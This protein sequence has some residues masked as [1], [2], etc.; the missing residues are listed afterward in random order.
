[1]VTS[2]RL[3]AAA[4]LAL[5]GAWPS[6][7]LAVACGVMQ[8]APLNEPSDPALA[9]QLTSTLAEQL[10]GLEVCDRVAVFDTGSYQPGC[11]T[12]DTCVAEFAGA[13]NLD[14]VAAGTL[15]FDQA[16]V[17]I[18]LRRFD[19][20]QG[21]FVKLSQQKV[22]LDDW[23]M[24]SYVQ[25]VVDEQF[26]EN[27]PVAAPKL[28]RKPPGFVAAAPE[29]SDFLE[30]EG[31]QGE[32]FSEID[33]DR[34]AA[35]LIAESEQLEPAPVH[36]E[37]LPEASEQDFG[38]DASAVA[39]EVDEGPPDVPEHVGLRLQGGY[40]RF[41]EPLAV[42]GLDV[43]TRLSPRFYLDVC[44]GAQYGRKKQ[45][46]SDRKYDYMLLP[47]GLGVGVRPEDAGKVD[48]YAG[49]DALVLLYYYNALTGPKLAE[50]AQ[51]RVG[52]EL[53]ADQRWALA[54][55]LAGGV[56]YAG[57]IRGYVDT[58][59]TELQPV[60]SFRTGLVLHL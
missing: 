46:R 58:T 57:E 11:S 18:Q 33:L 13:F 30:G 45:A 41:H 59:Y 12:S 16:S 7:A 21:F 44:L 17:L 4:A 27:P 53:P 34:T 60:L 36:V 35:D 54:L 9:E 25:S 3:T 37:E 48:P 28:P 22:V 24:K 49:I 29:P 39:G 56:L 40:V 32:D 42:L 8:L 38:Q 6:A 5:L 23:S 19:S 2:C 20:S 1:M 14:A 52:L 55:D 50:G 31:E 10:R 43:R 15:L 47:V 51:L 26:L